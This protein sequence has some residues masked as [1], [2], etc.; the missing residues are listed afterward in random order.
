[1]REL[2]P[3]ADRVP[4]PLL[5]P[6]PDLWSELWATDSVVAEAIRS[7]IARARLQ[8]PIRTPAPSVTR[9]GRE[10]EVRDQ[11]GRLIQDMRDMLRTRHYSHRTEQAYV[12]WVSRFVSSLP[13]SLP[14]RTADVLHAKRF[15][16]RLAEARISPSTQ[17]Q[18]FSAVLFLF[19]ELLGQPVDSFG[20]VVRAKRPL[21]VP[22]VLTRAEVSA[23]LGQMHGTAALMAALLYGSGLR[24]GECCR[25]RIM[26]LDFARSEIVVRNGKGAKDRVTLL[27]QRLH[28]TLRQHLRRVQ[29]VHERDLE[30][31]LGGV[32]LPGA[33]ERRHGTACHEWPWQWVFPAPRLHLDE[34]SGERRRHHLHESVLQRAFAEALKSSG[35]P[36]SAS[37]HSLRHSFATHLL[38]AGCDLRTL[39]R[40]LGH[41]DVSTTL[42]YAHVTHSSGST[43]DKRLR[44]P[45]DEHEPC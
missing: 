39:Q 36:K 11:R 8:P 33:L 24:V 12:F 34:R 17:N 45:L 31:N 44:S 1:M 3:L 21:R 28:G 6:P 43:G 38:E 15:L 23:V 35:T 10:A 7:E 22:Q 2:F 14:P 41:S 18:A 42:I 19:R 20:E 25:L 29:S 27:P 30:A 32:R 13:R 5:T 37:C 40:L 4:L 26:D 9:S 16:S